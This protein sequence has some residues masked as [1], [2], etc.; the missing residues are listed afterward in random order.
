MN[1]QDLF[2]MAP[3]HQGQPS[4]LAKASPKGDASGYFADILKEF[5]AKD[6]ALKHQVQEGISSA[7][8]AENIDPEASEQVAEVG[9]EIDEL[10][11]SNPSA[12][13]GIARATDADQKPYDLNSGKTSEGRPVD[14]SPHIETRA[15][16]GPLP[17]AAI[18]APMDMSQPQANLVPSQAVSPISERNASAFAVGS[19]GPSQN[20]AKMIGPSSLVAAQQAGLS[21]APVPVNSRQPS[22]AA[23]SGHPDTTHHQLLTAT[24]TSSHGVVAQQL[25]ALIDATPKPRHDKDGASLQMNLEK[26]PASTSTNVAMPMTPAVTM[27]PVAQGISLISPLDDPF[28]PT[29]TLAGES[30]FGPATQQAATTSASAPQL[31][32]V[33]RSY[34]PQVASQIATA[35]VQSTSGS[36][37]IALNP[38]ELGRVRITLTSGEAGLS[39]SILAERPETTDLMRRNI[40]LLAREFREMGHENLTFTFGEN[41]DGRGEQGN[42]PGGGSPS[43]PN[44]TLPDSPTPAITVAL[45]GG[46]DLKL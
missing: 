46:L 40:E 18:T 1:Q 31:G 32:V 8:S 34:A 16:V 14:K 4:L 28:D 29:R 17:V 33:N 39:I 22:L 15:V 27:L 9:V 45:N 13:P 12:D 37:E 24:P 6:S 11:A 10:V 43:V 23:T 42:A 25:A 19:E 2:I 3:A 7:D 41:P 26:S 21:M 35:V 20:V 5:E 30:D 38:E 36:T 44:A